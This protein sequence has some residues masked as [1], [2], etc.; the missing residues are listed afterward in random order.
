MM[1]REV[2]EAEQRAYAQGERDARDDVPELPREVWERY[3]G[4][5][6]DAVFDAY[7]RGRYAARQ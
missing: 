4:P 1:P 5:V 3:A 2:I 6:P 7:Q